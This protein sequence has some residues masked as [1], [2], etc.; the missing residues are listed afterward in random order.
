MIFRSSSRLP[1]LCF[2]EDCESRKKGHLQS[3]SSPKSRLLVRK[4]SF[5]R[6]SDSRRISRFQCLFCK[7]TFSQASYSD[8]FRQKKRRVN[9]PLRK[10]LAK[11]MPHREAARFLGISRHTVA[12]KARFLSKRAIQWQDDFLK[13]YSSHCPISKVQFDEM[14]SFEK[15]KCLPVSIPLVVETK[16]RLILGFRVCS[17]PSKGHLAEV[18]RKKYG[19]RA[20]ERPESADSLFRELKPYLNSTLEIR[21]DENPKYPSWIRPHFP[22]ARHLKYKGR[23]GYAGGLGELKS[24]GFD[25]LF[26]LN[27]TA[28]M[29]RAHVSRLFRRTWNTTKKKERLADHIA[30]Y[31]QAHNQEIISKLAKSV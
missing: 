14:E 4:G 13:R 29:I 23:R 6:S 1:V 19:F 7:R 17:M 11:Q 31:V 28:A 30:I 24:G 20:D 25:P 12:A 26:S 9:E 16:T 21:S 27:H 8:C 3:G 2:Y 18:S 10:L 15:S 22:N 5:L